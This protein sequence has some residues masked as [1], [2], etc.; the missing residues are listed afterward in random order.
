[1]GRKNRMNTSGVVGVIGVGV[2]GKREG[3]RAVTWSWRH[4]FASERGI[5]N[6]LVGD[7]N[8]LLSLARNE[9]TR[10]VRRKLQA[11]VSMSLSCAH[12]NSLS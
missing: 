9:P 10:A 3:N 8:G 6:H 4:S 12:A 7:T 2:A 11:C 5:A 1:M